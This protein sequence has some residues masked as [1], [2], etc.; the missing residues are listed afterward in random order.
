[1]ARRT[2][3]EPEARATPG[4]ERKADRGKRTGTRPLRTLMPYVLRYRAR[5][6][7]AL[8]ALVTAALATLALPLAVR[9]V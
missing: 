3:Q 2:A 5:L 6:A 1:M 7:M 8:V 9:R 4:D